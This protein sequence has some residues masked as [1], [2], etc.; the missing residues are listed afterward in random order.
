MYYGSSIQKTKITANA[1]IYNSDTLSGYCDNLYLYSG[2]WDNTNLQAY[3][4]FNNKVHIAPGGCAEVF[5]SGY[6]APGYKDGVATDDLTPNYL[7]LDTTGVSA[8]AKLR[9]LY[10]AVY[11]EP[12]N[13][14]ADSADIPLPMAHNA[15]ITADEVV[16]YK[17][18]LDAA[19][20]SYGAFVPGTM[21]PVDQS[22][23]GSGNLG[24]GLNTYYST[25]TYHCFMP[26]TTYNSTAITQ[27]SVWVPTK[28]KWTLGTDGNY[29][30]Y[31]DVAMYAT[32][33][34][35]NV[36]VTYYFTGFLASSTL[37][38]A[39]D[40]L[41]SSLTQNVTKLI[42]KRITWVSATPRDGIAVCP[43]ILRSGTTGNYWIYHNLF[44]VKVF[45]FNS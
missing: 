18:R 7:F 43:R 21:G 4:V 22:T 35:A 12:C 15:F 2:D 45:P 44:S 11:L 17:A 37:G 31:L 1:V 16:D 38:I 40:T 33:I 27:G 36:S 25:R 19:R 39:L 3:A 41:A 28:G 42:Y 20:D 14:L 34:T 26:N 30:L 24:F 5:L 9:L 13:G 23:T 32:S 6:I 8:G 29:R 10:I